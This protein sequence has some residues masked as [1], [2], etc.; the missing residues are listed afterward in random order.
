MAEKETLLTKEGLKRYQDEYEECINVKRPEIIQRIKEARA[1]GDLSENAEYDQALEDQSKLEGHILELEHIL[2]TAKIIESSGDGNTISLGN[3]VVLRDV[4][5][6]DEET[7]TLVGTAE[8]DPFENR[9]SNESP[10]GFAII[11]KKAGDTVVV[12]TPAGELSYFI[13][14]IIK[15]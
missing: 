3:T 1:Q 12:N 4:E 10:V 9:I 7:Y 8:A 14:E 6:G 13:V 11:G 5:T 2:K 15:K